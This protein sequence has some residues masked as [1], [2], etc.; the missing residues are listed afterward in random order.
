MMVWHVHYKNEK[1]AIWSTITDNY[2]TPWET[3]KWI[4]EVYKDRAMKEVV[5][6][7]KSN[8]ARADEHGCSAMPPFRCDSS[9][10]S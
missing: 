5:L 7:A 9:E 1:Y 2:I 4:I 3:E 6:M 10:L 8:I